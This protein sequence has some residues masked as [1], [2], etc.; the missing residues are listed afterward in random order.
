LGGNP[1][2]NRGAIMRTFK[3]DKPSDE[4]VEE[5]SGE[6]VLFLKSGADREGCQQNTYPTR[7]R[8]HL[9]TSRF[10]LC[11]LTQYISNGKKEASNRVQN[12]LPVFSAFL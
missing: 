10:M 9:T 12:Y 5:N 1:A 8:Y 7:I 3:G 11:S 4:T 6:C 2:R